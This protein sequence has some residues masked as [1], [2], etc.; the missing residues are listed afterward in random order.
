MVKLSEVHATGFGTPVDTTE[1]VRY[2]KMAA[3]AVDGESRHRFARMPRTGEIVKTNVVL[4]DEYLRKAVV[5]SRYWRRLQT[6]EIWDRLWRSREGIAGNGR[7][8][9]R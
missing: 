7:R 4:A 5:F 9:R 1:S 2:L 6:G 8:E 3:D